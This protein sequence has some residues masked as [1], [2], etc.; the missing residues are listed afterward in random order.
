MALE[1]KQKELYERAA[2]IEEM[3]GTV[4]YAYK[5]EPDDAVNYTGAAMKRF[6]LIMAVIFVGFAVVLAVGI[7]LHSDTL[8]CFSVAMLVFVL[9]FVIFFIRGM[10]KNKSLTDKHLDD[11]ELAFNSYGV[12]FRVCNDI[13]TAVYAYEWKEFESITEY[14][15][16]LVGIKQNLAY[17]FPKRVFSE[18]EYNRF[19][20][21]SHTA[22]GTKCIYKNFKP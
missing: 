7:I 1:D 2:R 6:I 4:K 12:V 13:R 16:V 17:I 15:K 18:E 19:R 11:V 21:F 3:E 22:I 8:V 14:E 10:R 9:F 5:E 20:R